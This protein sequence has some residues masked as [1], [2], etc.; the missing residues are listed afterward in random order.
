MK[1]ALLRKVKNHILSE[2]KRLRMWG[3]VMRKATNKAV[4]L[5]TINKYRPFAKCGTAACIAGWTCLLQLKPTETGE[6][7]GVDYFQH[8][9]ELLGLSEAQAEVL[10]MPDAWPVE[11]KD[12]T[13]DDGKR[14]T[15][16]VAAARIEHFI[17]TKGK[18]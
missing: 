6:F 13:T 12:G 5:A 14:K 15:A 7:Y 11:F 3:Y 4:P 8:A 9:Q 1:V 17:K 16:Q 10:F 18:E 2:P